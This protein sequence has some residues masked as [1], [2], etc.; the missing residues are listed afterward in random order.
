MWS[1]R[2]F[3]KLE[4]PHGPADPQG[5]NAEADTKVQL[6]SQTLEKLAKL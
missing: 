6:L 1:R 4:F 3:G 2:T 5:L